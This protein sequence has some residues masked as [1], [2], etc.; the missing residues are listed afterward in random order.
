MAEPT[1][2]VPYE[3]D[4]FAVEDKAANSDPD[5]QQTVETVLIKDIRKY[6]REQIATH[7]S[8]DVIEPGAEGVMT[9]Q[10]QVQTHKA[11]VVH[12]RQIQQMINN[13]VK[14]N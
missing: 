10:Q 12:L 6:L 2:D 14:E 8:F 9:T 5:E 1:E 7:N 4:D 3:V 11:V 13:K